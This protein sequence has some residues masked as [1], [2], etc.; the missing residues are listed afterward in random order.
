[1]NKPHPAQLRG[2]MLGCRHRHMPQVHRPGSGMPAYS[3][4]NTVDSR[5]VLQSQEPHTLAH[6]RWC[7]QQARTHT[8]YTHTL[9][10]PMLS[11]TV[12]AYRYSYIVHQQTTHAASTY[13][14]CCTNQQHT[15][16]TNNQNTG[17][18]SPYKLLPY[19]LSAG[20]ADTRGMENLGPV[21]P[22]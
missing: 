5:R 10:P 2:Y 21:L 7:R 4:G 11:T 18:L 3:A 17:E 6:S 22:A 1:M 13:Q 16:P 9:L 14:S 20:L 12:N 19:T 8:H 15:E